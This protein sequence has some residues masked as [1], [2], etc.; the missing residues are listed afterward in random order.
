VLNDTVS[1]VIISSFAN[2]AEAFDYMGKMKALAPRS[3]VPWLPAGK[4]SFLIISPA[5]LDLLMT[6]KDMQAYRR[7]LSAAYPGK[8]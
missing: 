6:N 3:I 2:A 1:L 7:F 4:Y 5:N 8:F